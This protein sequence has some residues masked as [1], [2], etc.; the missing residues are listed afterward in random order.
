MTTAADP[1]ENYDEEYNK[2]NYQ[3]Q[4]VDKN[5][6]M[7]LIQKADMLLTSRNYM[8]AIEIYEKCTPQYFETFTKMACLIPLVLMASS[9]NFIG[10]HRHHNLHQVVW[11]RNKRISRIFQQFNDPAQ[12]NFVG[13]D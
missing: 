8:R 11:S 6:L 3:E 12:F 1:E 9:R 4:K 7:N 5:K 13:A 10:T 2:Y